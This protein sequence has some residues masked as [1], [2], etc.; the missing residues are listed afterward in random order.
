MDYFSNDE[1]ADKITRVRGEIMD[2]KRG[3]VDN[4]DKILDRGDK[5]EL[6][7]DKAASLQVSPL[8]P[9]TTS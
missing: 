8:F 2:V 7:V 4:I 1:Y 5:I 6:L 3:M 9:H